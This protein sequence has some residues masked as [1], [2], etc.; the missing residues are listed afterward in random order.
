MKLTPLSRK[1][2]AFMSGPGGRFVRGGLGVSL[3]A[4]ALIQ[5]GWAL[6]L[7]PLG[8]FMIGTAVASY[9]PATLLYPE[10]KREKQILADI[11]TYKMDR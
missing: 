1:F 3:I 9:C 4:L 10:W 2:L 11:P 8:G 5:L 7:I 6:L